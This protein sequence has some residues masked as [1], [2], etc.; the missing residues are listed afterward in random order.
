MADIYG[1]QG[2]DTLTGT[3]GDDFINGLSGN[4]ILY[5]LEGNDFLEG[6]EGADIV[7][8]GAGDD[9]IRF[10]I[11]DNAVDTLTGGAGADRFLIYEQSSTLLATDRITDFSVADG[12]RLDLNLNN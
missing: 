9:V 7:D 11:Y 10:D 6:S 12:D 8:G 5:G 2:D 3:A 4:D 1:T